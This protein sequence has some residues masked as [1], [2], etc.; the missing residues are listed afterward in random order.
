MS[1]LP[2]VCECFIR[3]QMQLETERKSHWRC[4]LMQHSSD[5]ALVK[6]K[7]KMYDDVND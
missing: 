2:V 6:K 5:S 1:A 4:S 3:K 7:S